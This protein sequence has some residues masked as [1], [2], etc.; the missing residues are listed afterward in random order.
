MTEPS[1]RIL[2]VCSPGWLPKQSTSG[3]P[4]ILYSLLQRF[5]SLGWECGVV[6]LAK[7]KPS[8]E[9]DAA[10]ADARSQMGYDFEFRLHDSAD[11][12]PKAE[13]LAEECRRFEPD[14]VYCFGYRAIQAVPETIKGNAKV[15]AT[16]Y[17]PTHM[18]VFSKFWFELLSFDPRRIAITLLRLPLLA[19]R[20]LEFFRDELPSFAKADLVIGHAYNHSLDY[21][22]RLKRDVGYFPNPLLAVE[23]VSR[24][25]LGVVPNFLFTGGAKSTVSYTGL[26]FFAREVLPHIAGLLVRG[27]MT[28]TLVGGG[29]FNYE[30]QILTK[31][32]GILVKG[33]VSHAQLLAEYAAADALIVPT[34]IKLGFR[35]RIMDAF[36][37]GV[38]TIAHTANQSGFREMA[39]EVNCLMANTGEDFA[40][41]MLRLAGDRPLGQRLA[42]TALL[43]LKDAFSVPHYVRYLLEKTRI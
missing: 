36:R 32:P 29:N 6:S 20:F 34:P 4:M 15:V 1:K 33:H 12:T 22:R 3:S 39:N 37:H 7:L 41:Q 25:N 43:Q 8:P 18:S 28:V 9:V 26:S 42:Q 16:F 13:F 2:F 19:R 40:R 17:D 5:G 27:E 10:I 14:I 30:T 35:T 31:T 24:N 11:L 21:A 23:V 38:P